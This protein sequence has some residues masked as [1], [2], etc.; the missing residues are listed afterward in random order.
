MK[1][2]VKITIEKETPKKKI[3]EYQTQFDTAETTTVL[4]L[5]TNIKSTILLPFDAVKESIYVGNKEL[6]DVDLLPKSLDL[7]YNLLIK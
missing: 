7:E 5:K 1:K 6:K 4:E 3:T 2:S